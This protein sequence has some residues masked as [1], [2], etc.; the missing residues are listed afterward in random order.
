MPLGVYPR[1]Y[2]RLIRRLVL[3]DSSISVLFI[4]FQMKET[5]LVEIFCELNPEVHDRA[6]GE[7]ITK[8]AFEAVAK[9]VQVN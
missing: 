1:V 9:I 3:T 8:L 4:T 2:L 6:V 7:S 5:Y